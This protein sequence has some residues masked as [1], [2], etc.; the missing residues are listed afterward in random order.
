MSSRDQTS[1]MRMA[2]SSPPR[3][4]AVSRGRRHSERFVATPLSSWSPSPCPR[5]SFTVLKSSRSM[6]STAR[7]EPVSVDPGQGVLEPVL[8]QG[9]VGQS[10]Q[11]VVEG[12]VLELV[13]QADAVGDVAEAPDPADDP[14]ATVCGL[15]D[16]STARPSLN[17]SVSKLS[18][19]GFCRS[20][21]RRA[22]KVCGLRSWSRTN[23][24][25]PQSSPMATKSAA[26]RQISEK[27]RLKPAMVPSLSRTRIPSAVESSVA[28][29]RERAL[30]QLVFGGDLRRGVVRPRSRSPP[31]WGPRSG[32]R[33]STR[34]GPWS[35][36]RGAAARP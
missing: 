10:G 34:R 3:R 11:G 36:R 17:S 30:A 35:S 31:R 22:R 23:A 32:R 9:L 13:L 19:S 15:D 6:K 4:A 1:S 18:F 33:C 5:L 7:W 2:N 26:M 25:L 8:E 12:S 27:R 14:A 21:L 28:V 29:R 20:S 16:S 24:S